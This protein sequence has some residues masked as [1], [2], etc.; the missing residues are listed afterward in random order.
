MKEIADISEK[1][2]TEFLL[3]LRKAIDEKDFARLEKIRFGKNGELSKAYAAMMKNFF[4]I[5]KKTAS[6]EMQVQVPT[7]DK[8]ISG[9]YR[10]QALQ[11]EKKIYDEV[12]NVAKEEAL[13]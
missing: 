5:G 9:L 2:K 12:G 6:D 3:E 7:T 8:D 10:A 1:A 4:E 11:I 13:L